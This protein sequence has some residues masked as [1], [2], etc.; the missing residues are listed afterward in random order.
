M[1][2]PGW[3]PMCVA[4]LHR[5]RWTRLLPDRALAA[6]GGSSQLDAVE[7]QRVFAEALRGSWRRK[8][9]VAGRFRRVGMFHSFGS[10]RRRFMRCE[11]YRA[12]RTIGF[13]S[14]QFLFELREVF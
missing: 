9:H 14:S 10:F 11:R 2:R 7:F 8:A 4:R 6:A 3:A 1:T 5:S 12:I 13:D